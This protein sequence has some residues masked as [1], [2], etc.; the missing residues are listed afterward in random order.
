MRPGSMASRALLRPRI[1][2]ARHHGHSP[3]G[4]AHDSRGEPQPLL[5]Q[6]CEHDDRSL[7]IPAECAGNRVFRGNE[8][9]P[10]QQLRALRFADLK[11]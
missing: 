7:C 9:S 3:P 6:T 11:K 4:V 10:G 8:P 2:S 1:E 5:R